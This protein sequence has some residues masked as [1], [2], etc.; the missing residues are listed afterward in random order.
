[1]SLNSRQRNAIGKSADK[2]QGLHKYVLARLQAG[3]PES[4]VIQ[5]LIKRGID[6]EHARQ[7]VQHALAMLREG[8]QQPRQQEQGGPTRVATRIPPRRLIW[9]A[10]WTLVCLTLLAAGYILRNPAR[11]QRDQ[12][13]QAAALPS[14]VAP[15]TATHTP[16]PDPTQTATSAATATFTTVP[17]RTATPAATATSTVPPVPTPPPDAVVVAQALNLRA[18][19]G[20][21][22][23]V[24]GQL[25]ANAPLDIIGQVKSLNWFQVQLPDGQVGWV[26]G[27]AKLMQVNRSLDSIPAS[28]FRPPTG[29]VQKPTLPAGLGELRID[30]PG[31]SDGLVVMVQEGQAVAAAYIRAGESYT[32][33]GIPDG[34][35]AVFT[36]EGE[37]WDGI[38]F[39]SNVR[40]KN[41]AEP[42]EYQTTPSEYIRWEISL[43]DGTVPADQFPLVIPNVD[44][45]AP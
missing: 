33:T 2:R 21:S 10:G 15:S 12:M 39:T 18:G 28:Y 6:R 25:T 36:S 9:L 19:P 30:N 20:S 44:T 43:D 1:M 13:Q 35:Y 23:P 29:P 8:A 16:L 3:T 24:L 40:R 11:S 22:Y 42:F 17:T 32:I 27:D 14:E 4:D 7:V 45:Q 38:A 26:A 37:N 34:I 41:F 31:A 5:H